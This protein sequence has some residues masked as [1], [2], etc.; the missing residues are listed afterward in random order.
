MLFSR[1]FH[2]Q[3]VC[4]DSNIV[5]SGPPHLYTIH[6]MQWPDVSFY[7]PSTRDE[8]KRSWVNGNYKVDEL[9]PAILRNA[10][11]SRVTVT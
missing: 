5:V 11:S 9:P 4:L 6:S 8:Y 3:L 10:D 2:F 7:L 1:P